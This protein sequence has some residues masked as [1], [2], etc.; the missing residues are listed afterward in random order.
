[1]QCIVHVHVP[2]CRKK[3]EHN[4][5]N[6][7]GK[8]PTTTPLVVAMEYRSTALW[9]SLPH[10]K[11]SPTTGFHMF[12]IYGDLEYTILFVVPPLPAPHV[13]IIGRH[14]QIFGWS[15]GIQKYWYIKATNS[16]F[17]RHENFPTYDN[18]FGS[19][20]NILPKAAQ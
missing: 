14:R 8:Y 5:D 17:C 2:P 20:F 7:R 18:V 19:I 1:M 6:F 11:T 4:F 10:T 13:I 12:Y 3:S 9:G 15:A 16:K